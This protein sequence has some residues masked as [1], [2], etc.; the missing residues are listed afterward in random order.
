MLKF[1]LRHAW[2]NLWDKHMTTGRIN[3]VG[4]CCNTVQSLIVTRM[5]YVVIAAPTARRVATTECYFSPRWVPQAHSRLAFVYEQEPDSHSDSVRRCRCPTA[6][7]GPNRMLLF[8]PMCCPKPTRGA[9]LWS[10]QPYDELAAIHK[11]PFARI[12]SESWTLEVIHSW[13]LFSEMR[14][15]LSTIQCVVV[16]RAVL[17]VIR[18]LLDPIG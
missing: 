4:G 6:P 5:A 2:L 13:S 15:V 11:K 10:F 14:I 3:Q 12:H 9:S 7:C 16:S 8:S 17:V 18:S 1:V